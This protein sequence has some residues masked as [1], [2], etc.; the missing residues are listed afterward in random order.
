M[1][2]KLTVASCVLWLAGLAAFLIG[3][4]LQDSAGKWLTVGGEIVFFLGLALQGVL[5]A[6]GRKTSAPDD[7]TP[8]K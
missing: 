1:N 8:E 4:N 5:F 2:R 3:L 7:E 6:L